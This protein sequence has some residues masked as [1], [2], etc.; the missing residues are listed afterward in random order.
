[1]LT[2]H[3]GHLPVANANRG[4][5]AHRHIGVDLLSLHHGFD[6]ELEHRATPRLTKPFGPV[7]VR[8]SRGRNPKTACTAARQ[9]LLPREVTSESPVR[10]YLP[11]ARVPS[12][13][14]RQNDQIWKNERKSAVYTKYPSAQTK[15]RSGECQTIWSSLRAAARMSEGVA[16]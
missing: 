3:P 16:P 13:Q 14:W 10:S 2:A 7:P 9:A 5:Y 15:W 1:M 12:L 8:K 6:L 11:G 4:K